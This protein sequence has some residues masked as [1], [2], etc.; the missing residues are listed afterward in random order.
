MKRKSCYLQ[1]ADVSATMKNRCGILRGAIVATVG[2]FALPAMAQTLFVL[3][4][5]GK[6]ATTTVTNPSLLSTPLAITGVNAGDT[7]VAID[8]RPQNQNLYALGV[9]ATADTAQLYLLSTVT[10]FAAPIGSAGG[11]V[12]AGGSTVDF[13]ATGWDIDF[14]PAVDR[15]RVVTSSGLSFR[16]NPNTGALVDGDLGGAAGTVAG[17][18]PDGAIN[19]ATTSVSA[20]AYTNNRPN[21]G[22]ITTLYTLDPTTNALFIQNPPNA[23][24]QTSGVTVTIFGVAVLD[25]TA[26]SG[27][28]IAPGVNAAASNAAV[29]SGVG[30]GVL[31]TA[32]SSNLYQIDLTTAV[33]TPLGNLDVRSF[34]ISPELGAAIAL[35]SA[36]SSLI[37]FDPTTPGTTTSVAISG[38]AA[39]EVLVGIDGRPQTG[40]TYGLGVNATANTATLYLIDPQSA[41]CTAV[42]VA[43]QIAFVDGSG[44][45]V[46]LPDAATVG[47]GMD[48]NPTVDRIRIVTGSGLNFRVNPNTG[49]PVDGDRGGAAGTVAGVNTDGALS[50]SGAAS[51]A[52]GAA[53]TNS[54]AQTLTGGVTTQYVL[55]ATSNTLFIQ[56]P[57][58]AGTLTSALPVTLGG[59]PLDFTGLNGFD[60]PSTVAVTTSGTAAVGQ[61]YMLTTVGGLTGIYRLDLATGA[62]TSIGAFGSGAT[63][64]TGLAIWAVIPNEA[65][66]DVESPVGTTILD[67]GG[68][69][70][71]GAAVVGNTITRSILVK[72]V[73]GKTLAYTT[74]VDGTAF[75]VTQNPAANLAS[76]TSTTLNITFTASTVGTANGTLHIV[77]NDP[78]EASFEIALTATGIV[79]LSDDTATTT[80]GTTRLYPL[81]NDGLPAD[82]VV[83]SVSNPNVT[84]DGRALLIPSGFAGTFTYTA[85]NG[86]VSG[87]STVTVN[88]GTTLSNPTRFNGLITDADGNIFGWAN[89]GFSAGESGSVVVRIRASGG[90]ARFTFPAGSNTATALVPFGR[91][92]IVRNGDN[93]VSL[94][95][96]TGGNTLTGTLRAAQTATT[97]ATHHIALASIDSRI[98]GGGYAIATLG[99]NGAT[100]IAGLLPDGRPFSASSYLRDNGTIAFYSQEIDGT[101]PRGFFGGELVTA[102]LTKT[103][104]TGEI[105]WRKPAQQTGAL[106]NHLGGVNTILTANGS[107][108]TGTIPLAGAGTLRLS[109]GNLAATQTNAVTIAAGIPPVP[110]GSLR[111]WTAAAPATG[112]FAAK[113]LIPGSASPVNGNGIYLPKSN[114]AWGFFRGRTVGGRIELTVP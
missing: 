54:Y 15:L 78:D 17:A 12:N 99:T 104:V 72:N 1:L 13:P 69:V 14:N 101:N 97:P 63:T 22:N 35:D 92:T 90:T 96:L 56:T 2:L 110:T 36:G 46:D 81:A 82:A 24:T 91:L 107:L 38:V 7:L 53:Y 55:N 76:A 71:F 5:D 109:G 4:T 52:D 42:G 51:A 8:V 27:F 79:A 32:S 89:V 6:L 80:I 37:R 30:Y 62:A 43:G 26:V 58:N 106:G 112:R 66:I 113:V 49:A 85:G 114:S 20:A 11:Y 67:G 18:N 31:K 100:R 93:T 34:A 60:I 19:G 9:N 105:A 16:M 21:N 29:T 108:F 75:T 98:P 84:I 61:G 68:T 28:D 111:A 47:Y 88:V 40:Q 59:S 57:P 87:Q 45:P 95:V 70:G 25:F 10:G 103:D 50:L 102:N 41:A 64:T 39:G 3:T 94:S 65:D 83:T 23:G 73:G 33:A 44:N 74:A 48:F 86:T 77:S